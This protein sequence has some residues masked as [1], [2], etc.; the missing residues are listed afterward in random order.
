MELHELVIKDDLDFDKGMKLEN[1]LFNS[2]N[3]GQNKIVKNILKK[4]A[5]S[6]EFFSLYFQQKELANT[7]AYQ[8]LQ[9]IRTNKSKEITSDRRLD[10]LR[11]ENHT[12]SST[13]N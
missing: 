11:D 7:Q 9:Q 8:M 6:E 3:Q 2:K 10:T 4:A 12:R 5:N 1:L 13:G